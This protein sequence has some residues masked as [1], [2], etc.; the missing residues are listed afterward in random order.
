MTHPLPPQPQPLQARFHRQKRPRQSLQCQLL[1]K[2]RTRY[3][4]FSEVFFLMKLALVQYKHDLHCLK[5]SLK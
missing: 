3:E 2:S 5:V 4:E 1:C